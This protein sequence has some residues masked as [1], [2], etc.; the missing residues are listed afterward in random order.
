MKRFSFV[1][2]LL[3]ASLA[4][5]YCAGRQLLFA[6]MAAS[7][8]VGVP[9]ESPLHHHYS[10]LSASWLLGTVVGLSAFVACLVAL[11]RRTS[12]ARHP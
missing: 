9:S 2:V 1:A 10:V 4:W 12:T 8:L 11:V 3:I 6:C 7:A 5:T